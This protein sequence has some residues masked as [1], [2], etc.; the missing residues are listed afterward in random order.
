M[1]IDDFVILPIA[2]GVMICTEVIKRA[3]FV[4]EEAKDRWVPLIAIA[5]GVLFNTWYS[6]WA[7]DYIIF[8]NGLASGLTGIGMFSTIRKV[9]NPGGPTEDIGGALDE[10]DVFF[11]DADDCFEDEDLTEE[12]LAEEELAD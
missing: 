11:N 7:F 3:F 5:L 10:E 1:S 9:T 8:L 2:A 12:E 4:D 6:N